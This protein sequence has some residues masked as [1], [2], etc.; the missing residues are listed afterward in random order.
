VL[1]ADLVGLLRFCEISLQCL[2]GARLIRLEDRLVG[3]EIRDH[4]HLIAVLEED[5][6]VRIEPLEL[7]QL[8]RIIAE[9]S[10]EALE[11]IGHE[12]P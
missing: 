9:V 5:P 2:P 11:H 10:E 3:L 7:V 4:V 6:V 12:V 1:H 8:R